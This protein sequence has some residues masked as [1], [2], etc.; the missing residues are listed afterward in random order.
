MDIAC[1]AL[2]VF[3]ERHAEL[4]ERAG[5][6]ERR[7]DAARRAASASPRSAARVP[8]HAPRDFHEALQHY[9][10]CHLGVI[11]ELNGWDSFCPGHLD[12]HLLPFYQRGLADGTLTRDAARELLECF[13]V[14]FNNHPAPPKVG[15]TAAESGTYT[16]FA[17]INLGGLLADGSDGVERASPTCCSTSIDEMHLLQPSSNLQLSRK[18]PDAVLEHA[19]AR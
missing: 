19:P 15:V 7:P 10:F 5:G 18:T 1:D 11:T 9:W 13:F 17:N 12:Q 2:I 3:A 8:A 4:A 14:K 6:G 16:D